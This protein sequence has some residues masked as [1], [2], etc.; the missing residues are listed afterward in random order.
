MAIVSATDLEQEPELTSVRQAWLSNAL[1][2]Q[3]QSI[4]KI[5]T[6]ALEAIEV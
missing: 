3:I 2:F 5:E 1:T 6:Y 4:K